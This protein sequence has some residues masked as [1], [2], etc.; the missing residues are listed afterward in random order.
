MW[1]RW[2]RKHHLWWRQLYLKPGQ[3]WILPSQ[4]QGQGRSMAPGVKRKMQSPP[5]CVQQSLSPAPGHTPHSPHP[6]APTHRALSSVTSDPPCTVSRNGPLLPT[7][8]VGKRKTGRG[9]HQED[10]GFILRK[11]THS[12]GS[13]ITNVSCPLAPLSLNWPHYLPLPP[14]HTRTLWTMVSFMMK[15]V[16]KHSQTQVGLL[17][18][19]QRSATL[20]WQR[21]REDDGKRLLALCE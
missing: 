16:H 18:L 12:V 21:L 9:G 6:S 1:G 11:V 7:L 17:K 15:H 10:S 14:P 5:L 20:G 3:L 2:V 8:L 19:S 4:N 13:W